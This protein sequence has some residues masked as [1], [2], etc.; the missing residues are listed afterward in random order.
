MRK[1]YFSNAIIYA[2][3]MVVAALL[4]LA[5]SAL[6]V[7]FVT[8]L[9]APEFFVIAIVRAVVGFLTGA[10]VLGLVIG[11]ESY[12]SV[13]FDPISIIISVVIAAAIHFALAFILRFYP[14]VAGGTRYLAGI[15]NYGSNFESFEAVSDIYLWAYVAAF[16]IIKA[17]EIGVCV[18]AGKSGKTARLKN[19]ETIQGYPNAQESDK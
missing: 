6:V 12:K 16:W 9:V 14:F 2:I 5:V 4:N 15:L 19:R 10:V 17:C 8:L 11:Y 1:Q 3:C 18:I 13:T 7:K